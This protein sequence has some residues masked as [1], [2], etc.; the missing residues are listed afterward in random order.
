MSMLIVIINTILRMVLI[1]LIKSIGEDTH[2]AQLKSITNGVFVTQF[3]NTAILLLLV[4]A[5]FG[6]SGLPFASVF[7]GV[8]PDYTPYWYVQIGYRLFQTMLISCFFPF[9]EFGIAFSKSYAFKM[10]DRSFS[11]DTYKTKKTSIQMYVDLYSGPEYMI[12][13]K[14][15]IILNIAFV[16]MMYG[17]GIPLLFPVAALSYLILYSLERLL[18]CYFYQ[19]PPAFDDKM[20][21]NAVGIL[22]WAPL[23]YLFFGYWQLSNQQVFDNKVVPMNY[24]DDIIQTKHSIGRSFQ[25]DQAI[26]LFLMGC[27][28]AFITVM[29]AFFKKTMKA[30]GFGF[31]GRS[32]NV[33][34]N[35]PRFWK[36]IRFSDQDW[37]VQENDYLHDHYNFE[38]IDDYVKK[39]LDEAGIAKKTIQ[40]VPYY[41]V[42]ANPRYARDFQ[43]ISANTPNRDALIV[44]DDDEEGNDCEQSDMVVI[45][46]N[47]AYIPEKAL[48]GFKFQK[49]FH[50]T[51]SVKDV[52]AQAAKRK[53]PNAASAPGAGKLMSAFA[54]QFNA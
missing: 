17:M 38:I 8:F 12:H 21:K 29:Q 1:S 37:L 30:W 6:D 4:N 25:V 24:S 7:N 53:T 23:L 13:F 45:I 33:D 3:F 43:Y 44:D 54:K 14:Y 11:R 40:G 27:V 31:G 26:P 36:A 49:G 35:L 34:E 48:E 42:L 51:F 16:M 18:V 47:M 19:Q 20:T 10:L 32:I 28:L 9:I 15:S 52:A 41:F 5:N 39:Q 46:L 50:E 22:K 2:S